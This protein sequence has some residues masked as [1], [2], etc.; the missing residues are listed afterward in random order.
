MVFMNSAK[1]AKLKRAKL[2]CYFLCAMHKMAHETTVSAR[3]LFEVPPSNKKGHN[4][5]TALTGISRTSDSG[6]HQQGEISLASLQQ[7]V[8]HT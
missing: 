2:S 5:A 8:C 7:T 1:R 6:H 3:L 4:K